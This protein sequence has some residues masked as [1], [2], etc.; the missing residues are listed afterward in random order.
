MCTLR[1][2]DHVFDFVNNAH[3]RLFGDRDAVGKPWR[4]AFPELIGQGFEEL[5][6]R[7]YAT[8]ERYVAHAA[9]ARF[10]E[11]PE[12]PEEELFLDFIYE[13][14]VDEA[15][16]IIGIFCEGHDVT[17]AHR[18]QEALRESEARLA[19]ALEAG[20][21]GVW[22][23]DLVTH[24]AW[25]SLQ[26]DRMFGYDSLL[27]EWTYESFLEH[28]LPEDR[29]VVDR[30]F[31]EALAS[32]LWNFEARIRRADGA[33]RW[34][35]AQGKVAFDA[36]GQPRSMKGMVR[37]ISERKEAEE[38]LAQSE[39]R[40]AFLLKLSDALRPLGHPVEIQYEACRL[41]AEWLDVDRAYYVEIDEAVG[42]ARVARDFVRDGVQSLAGTHRLADYAWS[43]AM[44]RRGESYAIPD[45]QASELVPDAERSA[46]A[47][48]QLIANIGVPLIKDGRLVGALCLSKSRPRD[49]SEAEVDLVREV[50]ERIWAAAEQARAEAAQRESEGRLQLAL[51]AASIGT[52]VWYPG[53][54]RGEPDA[55][56]LA[57]FG[58]PPEGGLNLQS[59]LEAMIHPGDRDR[60]AEAAARAT[61]P[62]GG[63]VLD[64][65]IRLVLPDGTRRWV[66]IRARAQFEGDPP[67]PTR[68]LGMA[69]DITMR[70]HAEEALRE[71]ERRQAFL[72]KLGDALRTQPNEDAVVDVAVRMLAE[73]LGLD[74]CY[75]TAMYP[76]EDRVDVIQEFRRPDLAP[77]PS[78]LRFSDFPEAGKRTFDR[79]L[80]F[81]DTANDPELTDTDKH[82]LAAMSFGALLSSPLRRGAG[83]PIWALGAVSSRPRRWTPGEAALVEAAT[84][85]T[86]AA[87]E[88]ARAEAALR[89]SE[90]R[91]RLMAN[92][93]PQIVWITDRDG[94]MEFLNRQ[95]VDYTGASDEAWTHAEMAANFMH[96]DDGAAVVAAFEAALAT[97]EPF[98]IEHRIRS[99][100]GEDRWFL[101]RAES[102]RDPQ[103]GE[104]T[105]WFGASVD[106]HDRKLAEAALRELNETLEHQVADR[107]VELRRF[108]DIIE[109][110]ASPICAFD[111]DYRLIA[112]NKAHNDE[113]RRV[114]GFDTKLGDVFPDLFIPEQRSVMRALM[115]RALTGEHFTVTEEFGRPELGVPLWEISYTPLRDGNDVI[116]GAFHLATDISDRLRAAAELAAAQEALRQSQKME[117]MGQLTGGVAHDFNNL[118]TP[119][120][121]S[122]DMLMRRGVGSERERR[123]IEGGLQSADRAKVLVQRLLAFAR[124]QPL[125][126]SAVDLKRLIGG[127]ADLIASTSGPKVDVRV[128]LPD[129][130]PPVRA[131]ANQLEMALLNLA[132]NARDAMPDGGVLTIAATR[133]SV[134]EDHRSR[135]R[136]GHYVRLCVSDTGT[137]MDEATLAR[138]IEPFF[139]TKGIG[140]GT[141][142]GLSMVHGLAAQLNGGLTI[143]SKL[144]QGT[145]IELWLP[146]SAVTSD[147]EDQQVGERLSPKALGTALLVDDEDLVRMSTADMLI[148]LGFEVI[149]AG[150]A[151]EALR[152][153]GEG[154]KPDLL[155]TD[156]LMPGMTGVELADALRSGQPEL[157]VLVVSGYAE[158]D[159][160]AAGLP[161]LTKPFRNAELAASLA[162]LVP[163]AG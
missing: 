146:I 101:A 63:G 104:I 42:V 14:M 110:T 47:A 45:T 26:H 68:M 96:A 95:F 128:Q 154:L 99:A 33:V 41:L 43:I 50:S 53:E 162:A 54:D 88:R 19:R 129:D 6:D 143:S 4:E 52:F 81:N 152:L 57:L 76:A 78:P 139:S 66:A 70:K 84:E 87:V 34:L 115:D 48:V 155:V 38:A 89:E 121:G 49:W 142:L 144:G 12:A 72:L 7:V 77:M 98:E 79:T 9:P 60:Y 24:G 73:E 113:F 91:F 107:T 132:V 112:F 74:R 29:D 140:K 16:Q 148:D 134:R 25:R 105:R 61:N 122:L 120:I 17:E 40:Q 157:P 3:K 58:Q 106:I 8:G 65:E 131:D 23:L 156:H 147:D 160:V 10:R 163:A 80:I 30:K 21:L 103:T 15:G 31:Q 13:P 55:Q 109:A 138:A 108:R 75:A 32:G 37:D 71:S 161:R 22:E 102:Y 141:G 100:S 27:P 153:V 111:T 44:L 127:M 86:W 20:D 123:L 97:G 85:R 11:T 62:A 82:S 92:A 1:G 126:P 158:A 117:A 59:A 137:G 39:A 36:R 35:W 116:I 2:P 90:A 124:R 51:E 133:E 150:S 46:S 145:T 151:E 56:M 159:G 135:L 5:L 118:L 83:N 136:R 119:I 18:R 149:E 69:L 67:Q 64:E 114:N 28:V 94:R 93:V 130:L 125:Q